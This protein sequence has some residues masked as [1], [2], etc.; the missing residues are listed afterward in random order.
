MS[1]V[2]SEWV[3]SPAKSEELWRKRTFMPRSEWLRC[4]RPSVL[5]I[6]QAALQHFL[7]L[8]VRGADEDTHRRENYWERT[9][10]HPTHT[11]R[12][13]QSHVIPTLFGP[14]RNLNWTFLFPNELRFVWPSHLNIRGDIWIES[15]VK[16][17]ICSHSKLFEWRWV[18]RPQCKKHVFVLQRRALCLCFY[19]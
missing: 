10:T 19:S 16:I 6:Y 5:S 3:R 7:L 9:Q 17:D 14:I 2:S 1:V 18:I 11:D 4:A 8:S 13:T 15:G 12:G